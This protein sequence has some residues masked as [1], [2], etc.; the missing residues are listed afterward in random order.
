MNDLSFLKKVY[1]CKINI[2]QKDEKVHVKS[3]AEVKDR[4]QPDILGGGAKA[5]SSS[6]SA[7]AP[8]QTPLLACASAL[9]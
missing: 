8:R 4:S 3:N 9:Q 7:S 2:V 5:I 1:K 6:V